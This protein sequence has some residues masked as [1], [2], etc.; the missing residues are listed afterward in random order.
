MEKYCLLTND[1]EDHSI[2]H[3]SLRYETGQKVLEEGMPILLDIYK[4]HY[5][6]STFYFTGYMAEKFPDVVKM[7]PHEHEVA[8]H[9]YSHEVKEAFDVMPFKKQ[10][11]HL[12]ISKQLLEDLAGMEVISFRAPALRVNR[13]TPV[14]LAETGFKIDSSVASQRFDM[15]LSFGGIK[16]LKWLTAPRKP[17]RTKQDNLFERGKGPLVEVPLTALL[18]PYVGTTMRIFPVITKLQRNLLHNETSYTGKPLVFDI[19][20][21][22]FLNEETEERVITRRSDNII[23]FLFADVLRGKLKI[24]NLGKAAIPLYE[25]MINWYV[26]RNYKF[27]TVKEYYNKFFCTL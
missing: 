11:E 16:K 12:R 13:D 26:K 19:H 2:W 20:P 22:E 24:K 27:I 5:V 10:V 15:F 4:R 21:N 9:G 25:E 3:N 18:F 23:S 7:I 1:V 14:A 6:K 17:Y 8:S